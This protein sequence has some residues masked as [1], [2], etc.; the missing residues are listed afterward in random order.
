MTDAELQA[1]KERADAAT[2]GPWHYDS[3]STVFLAD[4]EAICYV[5]DQPRSKN[6]TFIAAAR[7]DVPALVA[8]VER[9]RVE[10]KELNGKLIALSVIESYL[11]EI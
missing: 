9:L 8:E 10:A 7:E 11:E 6:A 4:A 3:Y 5:P 2:A 1:I